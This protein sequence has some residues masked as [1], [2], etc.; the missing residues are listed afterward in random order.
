MLTSLL[1]DVSEEALGLQNN[2]LD[3]KIPLSLTTL[4]NLGRCHKCYVILTSY[5]GEVL[6][7]WKAFLYLDNNLISGS[8]P[9]N[10][11]FLTNLGEY[12]LCERLP[13][14]LISYFILVVL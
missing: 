3:G 13:H 2:A 12:L 5:D 9:N 4:N 11:G 8:I 10:L 14:I 1:V 7:S 6:T